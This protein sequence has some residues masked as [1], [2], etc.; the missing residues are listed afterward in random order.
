[1]PI[2]SYLDTNVKHLR[3]RYENKD[4]DVYFIKIVSS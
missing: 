1:M 3:R 4:E 2:I